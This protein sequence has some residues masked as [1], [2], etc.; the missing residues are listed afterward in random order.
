M[1][2]PGSFI[3]ARAKIVQKEWVKRDTGERTVRIDEK[4]IQIGLLQEVMEQSDKGLFITI[5]LAT[6]D[7]SFN[8]RLSDIL[9]SHHGKQSVRMKIVDPEEEISVEM[10]AR[11]FR[12]DVNKDLLSEL[13]EIN[14]LQFTLK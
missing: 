4:F 8:D 11:K 5:P 1:L 3:F 13:E 14:G 10:P 9:K 12:V 6:L 2:V 7:A